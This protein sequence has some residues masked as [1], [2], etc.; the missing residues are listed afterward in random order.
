MEPIHPAGGD[1]EGQLRV[2]PVCT[3]QLSMKNLLIHF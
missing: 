3:F 1:N 2:S